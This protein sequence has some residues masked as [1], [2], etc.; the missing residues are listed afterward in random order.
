MH[1]V[2][3]AR[4]HGARGPTGGLHERMR[5]GGQEFDSSSRIGGTGR[6][7]SFLCR[8]Y[9][10]RL[11][12]EGASRMGSMQMVSRVKQVEVGVGLTVLSKH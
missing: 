6:F 1:A 7:L 9:A 5:V 10:V 12:A 8:A 3:V 2:Q 4:E 11:R